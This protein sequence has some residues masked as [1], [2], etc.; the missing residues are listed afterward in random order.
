MFA[1]QSGLNRHR[2]RMHG[3]DNQENRQ[4]LCDVCN[5][6]GSSK[7]DIQKHIMKACPMKPN[8]SRCKSCLE[9]LPSWIIG[10]HQKSKSCKIEF[11]QFH[12]EYFFERPKEKLRNILIKSINEMLPGYKERLVLKNPGSSLEVDC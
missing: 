9:P 11:L 7:I 5:Y 4:N 2:S 10:D 1:G 8:Y 3:A 12:L 6:E